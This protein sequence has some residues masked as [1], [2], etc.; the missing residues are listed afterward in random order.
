MGKFYGI[1]GF[2]TTQETKPGVWTEQII[3]KKYYG[4]SDRVYKRS[5]SSENLNDNIIFSSS[6]SIIADPFANENFHNIK[7]VVFMGVK[8]KITNV[9][10]QRPRLILQ[11]GGEYNG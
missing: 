8:W 3:E 11:L 4:N 9:E 7:Y 2:T 10:I 1:I 6:I 5:I